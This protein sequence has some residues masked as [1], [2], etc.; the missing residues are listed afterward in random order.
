MDA[1]HLA[2][3]RAAATLRAQGVQNPTMAECLA[4]RRGESER[5]LAAHVETKRTWPTTGPGR[6]PVTHDVR[7]MVRIDPDYQREAEPMAAK[8]QR[9]RAQTNAKRRERDAATRTA[10]AN[11]FEAGLHYGERD[12]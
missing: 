10:R 8:M 2:N 9:I 7:D 11:E 6:P 3:L 4:L 1:E 5:M 12:R